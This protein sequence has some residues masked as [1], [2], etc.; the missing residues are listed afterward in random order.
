MRL[1]ERQ[2]LYG[3]GYNITFDTANINGKDNIVDY[4]SDE[5][6]GPKLDGTSVLHWY[7]LDP[8]YATDYLN[9]E[10]WVYP[11]NDVQHFFGTGISNTNNISLSKSN[12][13]SAFRVSF[14]NKN[15]TGTVP[16]SSLSKN[17]L[18]ISGSVTG[19]LLSFFEMQTT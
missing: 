16:N 15:V 4:A 18:S 10:P 13:N 8:E 14:T 5:S 9:P 11:K 1:P 6:W 3:G 19:K 12:N 7:N 2:K 17:S